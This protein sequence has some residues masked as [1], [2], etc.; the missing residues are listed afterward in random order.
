MKSFFTF[1]LILPLICLAQYTYNNLQVNYLEAPALAKNYTYQNLRLYPVYAKES[2]KAQ[3]KTLGKYMS[4]QEAIQKKKL[5][6]TE[7]PGGGSVNNLTVENISADTIIIICGDVIKGGQQDRIVQKDVVLKPKSN[8][9]NL[10][11]FC[12]ESGRWS[13]RDEAISARQ[14]NTITAQQEAKFDSY[15]NKGS[16][17]LRKVVEKDKDQSKVWQK[18]EEMNLENKTTT[19]TKTYTALTNSTDFN[20]KLAG[21]IKF[22]TNKFAADTN[23]IGVIVVT[24][25]RV[26]GCDMF[27]TPALFKSQYQ[28]LLHS[29]VT[30]VILK[31][32]PVTADTSVVKIYMDKLL[33]DETTQKA[34]LKQ[35]GNAFI[36]NGKKL[37]VSNFD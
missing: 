9:Q 25:N 20:N 27:A 4:L 26:L 35:K 1:L 29:Y 31:G 16:M 13:A 37:R 12:V 21:Y 22:F 30:E 5:K 18:V 19:P 14:T 6:I 11:V 36:E 24:G 7:K 3:F 8:K 15:Y 32:Q 33:K 10:D 28:S 17:S 2:F 34:T 23:I